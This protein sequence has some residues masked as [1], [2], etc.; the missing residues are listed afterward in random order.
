[1]KL[2]Q[3]L[4]LRFKELPTTNVRIVVSIL[5]A[6]GTAV[7]YLVWGLSPGQQQGWVEWLIFLSV[8]AGIDVAQYLIKRKTFQNTEPAGDDATRPQAQGQEAAQDSP[9]RAAALT[10]L[11]PGPAARGQRQAPYGGPAA[12]APVGE[13]GG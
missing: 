10:S 9:A 2:P 6:I 7:R 11:Q 8:W 1:M 5:L 12:G 4:W 13:E 3:Q